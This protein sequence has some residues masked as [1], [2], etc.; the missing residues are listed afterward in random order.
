MEIFEEIGDS[1]RYLTVLPNDY[2]AERDYPLL[3][4]LHGFGANMGDLVPLASSIDQNGYIYVFPNAPMGFQMGTGESGFGW[5]PPVGMGREPEHVIRSTDMV[6]NFFVEIIEKFHTLSGNAA[7]IGF[8]QGGEMA[9]R[10]GLSNPERFSGLAALCSTN[11]TPEELTPLLPAI[12]KQLIF[13]A[14]GFEDPMIA[15]ERIQ[16]TKVFLEEEGYDVFYKGYDMGHEISPAVLK[17]L[18]AWLND[19]LPPLSLQ[20]GEN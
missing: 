9:Y 18:A 6:E 1:L 3:I 20:A 19:F 5:L 11:P 16:Q 15:P 8:S 4:F 14:E 2:R 12:R 13:I 7:L 10:C 17:D